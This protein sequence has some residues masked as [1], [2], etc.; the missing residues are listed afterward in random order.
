MAS[1][2]SVHARRSCVPDARLVSPPLTVS[3]FLL[4]DKSKP[5]NI[6]ARHTFANV[7]HFGTSSLIPPGFRAMPQKTNTYNRAVDFLDLLLEASAG[8][9]FETGGLSA[10]YWLSCPISE[11]T[12]PSLTFTQPI[13]SD[14]FAALASST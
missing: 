7:Y 12:R 11:N 10:F 5:I 6:N 2:P 3:F 13:L 4:E 14:L 9:K 1:A 8:H